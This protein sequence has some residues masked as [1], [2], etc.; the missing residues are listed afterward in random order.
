MGLAWNFY[1]NIK[2]ISEVN[3]FHI[4]KIYYCNDFLKFYYCANYCNI[5][6]HEKQQP[7][8]MNNLWFLNLQVA[9]GDFLLLIQNVTVTIWK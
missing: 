7:K 6:T 9:Y 4:T 2:P 3:C 5:G 1:D 8:N